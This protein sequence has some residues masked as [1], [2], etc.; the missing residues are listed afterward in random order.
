[1]SRR[2]FDRYMVAVGAAKHIK[3]RRLTIPERYAFFL[4]VL[5]IAAQSPVRGCLLVGDLR[6]EAEDVAAE[7][8]VN[9]GV[10][11]SALCKLRDV[12]VIV[13]DDEHGCEAVRDFG[14][15]NPAPKTDR[16]A[17]ERQRRRRDKVR[18]QRERH[19]DVTATSRLGHTEEVEEEVEASTEG[20]T[21][22]SPGAK[23]VGLDDRRTA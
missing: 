5:S 19:G 3:F 1:M 21:P 14:D 6:A 12:G 11:R 4:G 10:A 13:S 8:G 18:Q 22:T 15:W 20:A 16:T 9:V 2:Q 7:A 23:V 17:A